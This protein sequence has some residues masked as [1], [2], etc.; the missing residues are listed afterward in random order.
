MLPTL[1]GSSDQSRVS[2]SLLWE[3]LAHRHTEDTDRPGRGHTKAQVHLTS[4]LPS[5]PSPS[6]PSAPFSHVIL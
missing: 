5:S 4:P 6:S 2:T 1:T 3:S